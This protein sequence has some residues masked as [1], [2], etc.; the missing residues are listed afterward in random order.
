MVS[1]YAIVT[2]WE[3][4]YEELVGD[5][6]GGSTRSALTRGD[7]RRP[8]EAPLKTIMIGLAVLM[9]LLVAAGGA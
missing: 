6:V 5:A 9:A 8:L 4:G 7:A 3:F 1:P 2:L